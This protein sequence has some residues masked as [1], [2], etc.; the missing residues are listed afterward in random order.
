M[1]GSNSADDVSFGDVKYDTSGKFKKHFEKGDGSDSRARLL[2]EW[3]DLSNK[4]KVGN[5]LWYGA[6]RPS[7]N[8]ESCSLNAIGCLE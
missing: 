8:P 7:H 4:P 6:L 1:V 5:V 3:F 2:A